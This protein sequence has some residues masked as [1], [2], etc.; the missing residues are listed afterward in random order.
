[1]PFGGSLDSGWGR[2]GT[3]PGRDDFTEVQLVTSRAVPR[4]PFTAH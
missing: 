2:F 1:M 3:G 4:D